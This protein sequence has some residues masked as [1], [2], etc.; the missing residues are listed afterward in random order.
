MERIRSDLT[1][2]NARRP[3][4]R[5][6]HTPRR[7]DVEAA[8]QVFRAYLK[9]ANRR[10]LTTAARLSA[11]LAQLGI[12]GILYQPPRATGGGR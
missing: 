10:D 4:F 7:V 12:R 5:A 6:A 2:V 3:R 11:D 1:G 8:V 9:A